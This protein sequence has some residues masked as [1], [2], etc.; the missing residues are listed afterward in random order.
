MVAPD[1][2]PDVPEAE[3]ELMARVG[4][5]DPDAFEALYER[6]SGPVMAFVHG[7]CQDRALSEDLVQETFLRA[8]RAAPR[9]RPRARLS[10][11][12]FQIAKRLAFQ[13]LRR[14]RR[15]PAV[16]ARAAG[17]RPAAR[18]GDGASPMETEEEVDRLAAALLTLGPRLRPV[19]VLVR[20]LDRPYAET[21]AILR[22][23]VGTVKSR[24]A[25]AE[26][27]LRRHLE[28]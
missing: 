13:R 6:F 5:G 10:T 12:L 8:W 24:M 25:A 23:P 4:R 1:S 28:S 22:V 9:W 20:L 16:E 19:F 18:D 14:R 21:A 15:R 27:R 11:W 2:P 26:A 7:L 17:R 3:R